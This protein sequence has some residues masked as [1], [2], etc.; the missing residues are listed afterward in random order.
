M[1]IMAR[2]L[3][4]PTWNGGFNPSLVTIQRRAPSWI[5]SDTI[6]G[7]TS[8]T[9]GFSRLYFTTNSQEVSVPI[10]TG[11]YLTPTIFFIDVGVPDTGGQ[12]AGTDTGAGGCRIHTFGYQV[13]FKPFEFTMAYRL[14]IELGTGNWMTGGTSSGMGNSYKWTLYARPVYSE[15]SQ[16]LQSLTFFLSL[17]GGTSERY[18]PKIVRAYVDDV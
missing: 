8:L 1:N 6:K 9:G 7:T 13:P 10:K 18:R 4:S 15:S 12:M 14:S 3:D 16:L 5:A 17:S 11:Y 2:E